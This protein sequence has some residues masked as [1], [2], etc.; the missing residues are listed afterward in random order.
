MSKFKML[1]LDPDL[2]FTQY[3]TWIADEIDLDGYHY[4]GLK[5][6]SNKLVN[7]KVYEDTYNDGYAI[8]DF[9]LPDPTE[10]YSI[11]K[12]L[13]EQICDSQLA[14][15]DDYV[16]L[17]GGNTTDKIYKAK[18]SRPSF[19][20]DTTAKL[21]SK[22]YG[23]HLAI[24]DG[25]IY[26]FGGNNGHAVDNI[27]SASINDPLTWI[28]NGSCLPRKLYHSQLIIVDGYIYLLGGHGAS[29]PTNTISR[30]SVNNPLN[31]EDFSVLPDSLYG[32]H[33]S[34]IDGYIYLFGG[35]IKDSFAFH[36]LPTCNIYK[37]LI[38]NISEWNIDGY[39]PYPISFG[40]FITIGN[41]GYL[42]AIDKERISNLIDGYPFN[43]GYIDIGNQ[44]YFTK[45][46]SCNLNNSSNWN[47]LEKT[48]KGEIFQS[49]IAIIDDR[50]F[51]FGGN[52]SSIIFIDNSIIHYDF[53]SSE[54]LAYG[55]KT[56][57]QYHSIINKLDL[58]K[59]LGFPYWIA[60]YK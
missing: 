30:A 47:L 52:G 14:I 37:S 35:I 56:R 38:N 13:P 23:S 60:N 42:F 3:R 21:P 15:I 18:L 25:Y 16:Y 57:T 2:D 11:R 6:G 46:F 9:N 53:N 48:I 36:N 34:V 51:L 24:I 45:I 17:F 7:I 32:S 31:W 54:V 4:N 40:Q 12:T 28:D 8:V 41:K 44:T 29:E 22:L 26:L 43:Y 50:L 58:N 19:W 1:G 49:H 39:L 55:D 5:G 20:E 59:L 27:Y 33:S 10:W